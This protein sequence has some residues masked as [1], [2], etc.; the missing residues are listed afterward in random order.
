M[1]VPAFIS[2]EVTILIKMTKDYKVTLN[3]SESNL[4]KI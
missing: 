1:D 3:N 2:A 4:R